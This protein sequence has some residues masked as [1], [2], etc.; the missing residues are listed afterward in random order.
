MQIRSALITKTQSGADFPEKS[1]VLVIGATDRS[2]RMSPP[3]PAS[4]RPRG[5]LF[6]SRRLCAAFSDQAA[7]AVG[8]VDQLLHQLARLARLL[9]CRVRGRHPGLRMGERPFA[10]GA[11]P[12]GARLDVAGEAPPELLPLGRPRRGLD[13]QRC[14]RPPSRA[15]ILAS[16]GQLSLQALLGLLRRSATKERRGQRKGRLVEGGLPDRQQGLQRV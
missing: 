13:A 5:G 6:V 15:Q 4:R 12:L 1:W 2:R 16:V 11:R 10:M 3:S 9:V 14:A 8:S 7:L